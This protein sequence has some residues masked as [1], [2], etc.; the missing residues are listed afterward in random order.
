MQLLF[1]QRKYFSEP[2][3]PGDSM[4]S[5]GPHNIVFTNPHSKTLLY[6]KLKTFRT[7]QNQYCQGTSAIFHKFTKGYSVIVMKPFLP[8]IATSSRNYPGEEKTLAGSCDLQQQQNS[9]DQ[10][11]H[12]E[13][14]AGNGMIGIWL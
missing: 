6:I 2:I 4:L 10:E 13:M 12:E 11:N 1:F 7:K 5:F 14:D 9:K 3:A 8:G